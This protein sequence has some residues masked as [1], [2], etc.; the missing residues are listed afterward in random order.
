[1]GPGSEA[2]DITVQQLWIQNSGTLDL[3]ALAKELGTLRQQMRASAQ[4]AGEDISVGE[5]AAAEKD[6]LAANG[7]GTFQHLKNA[8]AW[9]FD[10]ATKIQ[11]QPRLSRSPSGYRESLVGLIR[12][13]EGFRRA[14]TRQHSWS[15]IPPDTSRCGDRPASINPSASLRSDRVRAPF[16]PI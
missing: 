3:P 13:N 16:P 11:W 1:M 5:V 12:S 6:A 2:H 10:V 9:A 8:G 4:S 7:P 15:A 14:D